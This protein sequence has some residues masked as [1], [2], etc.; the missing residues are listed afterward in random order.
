MYKKHFLLMVLCSSAGLFATDGAPTEKPSSVMK[1]EEALSLLRLSEA[2]AANMLKIDAAFRSASMLYHPDRQADKSAAEKVEADQKFK[3]IT[4][5][6]DKLIELMDESTPF[7][8]DAFGDRANYHRSLKDLMAQ[9]KIK[10]ALAANAADKTEEDEA[11]KRAL[12]ALRGA[13][14][15]EYNNDW[16]AKGYFE[17]LKHM[18]AEDEHDIF[19]SQNEELKTQPRSHIQK[20]TDFQPSL[21]ADAVDLATF[22]SPDAKTFGVGTALSAA[23]RIA[24]ALYGRPA[25]RNTLTR[26]QRD[27]MYRAKNTD[28][29]ED[30]QFVG[31]DK[32]SDYREA[33][34]T[35]GGQAVAGNLG[36]AEQTW[37]QPL[38]GAAEHG[39]TAFNAPAI[40]AYNKYLAE[41]KDKAQVKEYMKV[42]KSKRS[43]VWL[44]MLIEAALKSGAFLAH[45]KRDTDPNVAFPVVGEVNTIKM[46]NTLAALGALTGMA[47]RAYGG[48]VK[49]DHVGNA[50][51]HAMLT[52]RIS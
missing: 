30:D 51:D 40:I 36:Y 32:A 9:R 20:M 34:Y 3:K 6:K 35:Y 37:I 33:K 26:R 17:R 23:T 50:Q 52:A 46:A 44:M 11:Q 15:K 31:P 27:M 28:K 8:V 29:P 45:A 13:A 4:A 2:D 41:N 10:A 14:V 1:K 38:I 12:R 16:K 48:I 42:W 43:R 21:I 49:A 22:T 19:A 18:H 24:D 39:Y 47:R 7:D 5:A 25:V